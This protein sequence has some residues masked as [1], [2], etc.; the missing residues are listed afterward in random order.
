M[1]TR[2]KGNLLFGEKIKHSPFGILL[3][4]INKYIKMDSQ[5]R[6]YKKKIKD[7][8][9]QWF[10]NLAVHWTHHHPSSGCTLESSWLEK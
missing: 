10:P 6:G 3:A 5:V 1:I 8:L 7:T 4:K 2:V 9:K